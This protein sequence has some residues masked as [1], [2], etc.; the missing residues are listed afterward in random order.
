M[1]H[2]KTKVVGTVTIKD[3]KAGKGSY[4]LTERFAGHKLGKGSYTLSLQT[5]SGKRHSKTVTQKVSVQ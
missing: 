3:R 2:G 4:K 5:T 1:V